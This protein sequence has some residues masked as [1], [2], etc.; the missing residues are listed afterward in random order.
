MTEL[1]IIL[2]I[3]NIFLLLFLLFSA[4]TYDVQREKLL[5]ALFPIFFFALRKMP[6]MW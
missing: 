6:V 4:L 3:Y 5:V 1:K 2:S